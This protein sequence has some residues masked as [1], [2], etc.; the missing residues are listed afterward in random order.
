VEQSKCLG[1]PFAGQQIQLLH[2]AQKEVIRGKVLGSPPRRHCK[3]CFKQSWPNGRDNGDR[4]FVLE[5]E[6]VCQVTLEPVRP[7][8][9]ARH[10]INQLPRDANFARRLAHRPLKDVAHAEPASNL[11]YIDGF[12]FE[13]KARIASDHE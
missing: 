9:R 7:N 3:F 10:R 5:S 1:Q 6:N 11:L 2:G 12:A 4:D 13:R 8:V